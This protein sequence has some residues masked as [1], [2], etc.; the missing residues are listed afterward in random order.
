MRFGY[1]RHEAV[2]RPT[3]TR[4]MCILD[5]YWIWW[6][7]SKGWKGIRQKSDANSKGVSFGVYTRKYSTIASGATTI[8]SAERALDDF[9]ELCYDP[10]TWKM[11][12]CIWAYT[13]NKFFDY[14]LGGYSH[15]KRWARTRRCFI[16]NNGGKGAKRLW[17]YHYYH[18]ERVLLIKVEYPNIWHVRTVK[19][20]CD[21]WFSS[22]V[23]A[24]KL[25]CRDWNI[26]RR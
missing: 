24:T 3:I 18:R 17:G 16:T 9:I 20:G 4:Q 7:A 19:Q 1:W 11:A 8:G 6:F 2:T 25:E 14:S 10:M 13:R 21:I 5:E 26:S 15:R 12:H 23:I 22:C